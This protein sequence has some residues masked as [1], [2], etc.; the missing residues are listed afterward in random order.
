MYVRDLI[1]PEPEACL[2][3]DHCG[4][5]GA[6]MRRHNCG[7]VPVIDTPFDRRVV[8]VVTDRDIALDLTR[9]DVPAS[10]WAVGLC[11]SS[12][13][14]TVEADAP[15]D[16]AVALME[17]WALQRLPVTRRGRLVGVLS[18][19]DIALLARLE[20]DRIGPHPTEHQVA[21]IVEAI[22]ASR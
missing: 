9:T 17:R 15:I 22:A 13:A 4:T 11:M 7:F 1:S 20:S 21:E 8:G 14:V 6:I 10:R 16:D 19:K 3:T 5:V 18:L 12:P 2:P